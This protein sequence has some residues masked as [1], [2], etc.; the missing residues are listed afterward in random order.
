MK[1]IEKTIKRSLNFLLYIIFRFNKWHIL[2]NYDYIRPVINYLNREK[3][4]KDDLLVEIGCGLGNI[5]R[6]TRYQKIIGLD[7]D[8]NVIKAAKCLSV[9]N[10]NHV[11][12]HFNFLKGEIK[13]AIYPHASIKT[14][15]IINF[16]HSIK[17][18]I[19]QAKLTEYFAEGLVET[20]ILDTMMFQD[21]S[22][23]KHDI[24]FL[25]KKI[26]NVIIKELNDAILFNTNRRIFM[27][28]QPCK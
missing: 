23:R 11:F 6:S 8:K 19:I 13:K 18:E 1:A 25:T 5:C 14:L 10:G 21:S 17:P 9:L 22:T 28:S 15:I 12:K 20:I 27:L 16:L 3:V 4:N 2:S 26:D 7:Y 24:D